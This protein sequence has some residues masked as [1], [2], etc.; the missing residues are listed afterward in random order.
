MADQF[1]SINENGGWWSL[2]RHYDDA[3]HPRGYCLTVKA[4]DG[5]HAEYRGEDLDE[6]IKF[7]TRYCEHRRTTKLTVTQE[8][9][10]AEKRRVRK[11]K[12]P[13]R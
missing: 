10:A 1:S 2:R 12:K 11:V 9:A 6:L 8:R 5:T 7:G 13:G 3:E 4:E